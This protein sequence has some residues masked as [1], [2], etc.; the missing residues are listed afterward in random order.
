MTYSIKN[1]LPRGDIWVEPI[2]HAR[3]ASVALETVRKF[4]EKRPEQGVVVADRR[5]G[6]I[7]EVFPEEPHVAYLCHV[8]HDRSCD[9]LILQLPDWTW[10][11][12]SKLGW[13]IPADHE[14]VQLFRFWFEMRDGANPFVD[15]VVDAVG[16]ALLNSAAGCVLDKWRG[17]QLY[18]FAQRLLQEAPITSPDELTDWLDFF[19]DVTNVQALTTEQVNRIANQALRDLCKGVSRPESMADDDD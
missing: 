10:F 16:D 1:L 19:N 13:C 15:P 5:L 18:R 8:R 7:V 9:G 6:M 2:T 4:V 11:A 17:P 12:W 3:L 14:P